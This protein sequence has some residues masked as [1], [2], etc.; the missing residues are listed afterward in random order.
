MGGTGSMKPGARLITCW[1]GA[2]WLQMLGW[3]ACRRSIFVKYKIDS[4]WPERYM[5]RILR[6]RIRRKFRV[7]LN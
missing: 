4:R 6:R 1:L 5:E 7:M 3:L 2:I